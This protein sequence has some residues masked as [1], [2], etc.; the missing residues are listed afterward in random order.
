MQGHDAH[1]THVAVA[2]AHP[3]ITIVTQ[4]GCRTGELQAGTGLA[5]GY[6]GEELG[7]GMTLQGGSYRG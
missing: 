4:R 3:D 7:N 6:G 2:V 5:D 1:L